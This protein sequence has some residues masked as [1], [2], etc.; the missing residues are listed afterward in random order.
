MAPH[1][2]NIFTWQSLIVT[3]GP[4]RDQY[5]DDDEDE[6]EDEG[7]DAD[8]DREPPVIREPDEDE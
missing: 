2:E 6:E 7:G 4:P 3:A 8:E 1:M 5:D